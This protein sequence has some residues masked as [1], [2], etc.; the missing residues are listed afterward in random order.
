ML[1]TVQENLGQRA[2]ISQPFQRLL[3][4]KHSSILDGITR[5]WADTRHELTN[6]EKEEVSNAVQLL[7][8]V[9]HAVFSTYAFGFFQ[10]MQS[11]R[12]SGGF[13]GRFRIAHGKP[14]FTSFVSYSGP[15]SFSEAQSLVLNIARG[16]GLL[17][18]PLVFWYPCRM[19]PDIENGHCFL[20]D[21]IKSERDN[22]NARFKAAEF[23][24][25]VELTGTEGEM[26]NL[27][28]QLRAYKSQDPELELVSGVALK[29]QTHY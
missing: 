16:E 22:V 18:T 15:Q 2:V 20:F 24:C 6:I 9:C 7:A 19:H 28:S 3:E 26:R 4:G 23:P 8:N 25:P 10:G 21:K 29:E 17:L 27:V 1:K 5:H 14:P 12:F 13:K 11:E